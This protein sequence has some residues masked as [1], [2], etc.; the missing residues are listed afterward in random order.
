M[1]SDEYSNYS[2]EEEI[3]V[4]ENENNQNNENNNS[5]N[6]QNSQQQLN[7][8]QTPLNVKQYLTRLFYIKKVVKEE[9]LQ[10]I[11]TQYFP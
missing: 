3:N 10:Q 5:Q 8:N 4:D 1:S 2:M 9:D 11:I 7:A 6:E